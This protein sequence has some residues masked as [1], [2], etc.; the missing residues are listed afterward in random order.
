M[1]NTD[2]AHTTKTLMKIYTEEILLHIL[3]KNKTPQGAGIHL[4]VQ[5]ADEIIDIYEKIKSHQ[6]RGVSAYYFEPTNYKKVTVAFKK[7]FQIIQAGGG[8]VQKEN[9]ILFIKRLGKWDLPK[10]KLE[11]G[12]TKAQGAIREVE[13]ECNVQVEI[14]QKIGK[15]WH[16]FSRAGKNR[17]KC[18]H[19][20]AMNCLDDHQM[21]PQ[22]QEAIEQV[23][24]FSRDELNTAFTNTYE[25]IRYI[26]QKYERNKKKG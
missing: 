3:K 5:S 26:Y 9:K 7:H 20:Y 24:W 25:T 12:E 22:T 1:R 17:L 19:W 15:T 8:I 14:I 11:K 4:K 10:G 18:T 6:I 2:K 16:T 13:E 21:K 23:A